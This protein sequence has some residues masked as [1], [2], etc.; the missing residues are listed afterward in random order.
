MFRF[1]N[2]PHDPSTVVIREWVCERMQPLD[3]FR[4]KIEYMGNSFTVRESEIR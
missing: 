3:R 2:R 1:Y 4:I